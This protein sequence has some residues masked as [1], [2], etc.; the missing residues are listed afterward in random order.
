MKT[1]GNEAL[2]NCTADSNVYLRLN[3]TPGFKEVYATL[4]AAQLA[5]KKVGIRITEGTAPCRVAYVILNRNS[6]WKHNAVRWANCIANEP[7]RCQSI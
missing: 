4:L 5:D 3:A 7:L 2:A 1:S 6:W